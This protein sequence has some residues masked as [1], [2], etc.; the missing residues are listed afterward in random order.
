MTRR[1]KWE[2]H[3]R[4]YKNNNGN[5]Y[6]TQPK[7]SPIRERLKR[8]LEEKKQSIENEKK[9]SIKNE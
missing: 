9:Q 3:A 5:K 8:K 6:F 1:Q 4:K 7:A 2:K